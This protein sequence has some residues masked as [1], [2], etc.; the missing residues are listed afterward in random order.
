MQLVRIACGKHPTSAFP[1]GCKTGKLTE[2]KA[3]Q[4][5]DAWVRYIEGKFVGKSISTLVGYTYSP[6]AS[7]DAEAADD[8]AMQSVQGVTHA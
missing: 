7:G 4:V 2:E 5:K 1:P 8:E 6:T 3:K